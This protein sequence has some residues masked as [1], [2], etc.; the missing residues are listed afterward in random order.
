MPGAILPRRAEQALKTQFKCG[1]QKVVTDHERGTRTG[2]SHHHLSVFVSANERLALLLSDLL[3]LL[4]PTILLE[5]AQ[6]T[7]RQFLHQQEP[8][9]QPEHAQDESQPADVP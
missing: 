9:V 7:K 6:E 5:M 1:F 4:V 8:G 2:I 3:G